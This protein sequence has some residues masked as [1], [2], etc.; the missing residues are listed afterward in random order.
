MFNNI[1][2][3]LEIFDKIRIKNKEVKDSKQRKQDISNVA[4]VITSLMGM[5][6]TIVYFKYTIQGFIL[7][8]VVAVSLALLCFLIKMI[9]ISKLNRHYKKYHNKYA[10]NIFVINPKDYINYED[11]E[12]Y[13]K[14]EE[15]LSEN[16]KYIL[17][18]KNIYAHREEIVYHLIM[19]EIIDTRSEIL[20]EKLDTII[21]VIKSKLNKLGSHSHTIKMVFDKI[22]G[23]VDDVVI[24]EN[25]EAI[26]EI[27]EKHFNKNTIKKYEKRLYEV[28]A[29]YDEDIMDETFEQF[30]NN[31][32]K[33]EEQ[34][35]DEKFE[36]LKDEQ[37]EDEH[38]W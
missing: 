37:P 23:D 20:L 30:E 21:N 22:F 33:S 34:K 6:G 9:V 4:M 28:K 10:K 36:K 16:G 19:K 13:V 29:K 31:K 26:S 1:D 35:M 27:I 11:L 14:Y 25:R 24:Y 32:E 18:Q 17:S 15:E 7:S 8:I 12:E 2:K 5:L 3:D 38:V